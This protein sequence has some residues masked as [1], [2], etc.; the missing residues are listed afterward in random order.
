MNKFHPEAAPVGPQF[1]FPNCSVRIPEQA[2]HKAKNVL[3]EVGKDQLDFYR[4]STH[5]T[6]EGLLNDPVWKAL[7]IPDVFT[8][9]IVMRAQETNMGVPIIFR[10]YGVPAMSL[11]SMQPASSN[12]GLSAVQYDEGY[13]K[14][15]LVG[16]EQLLRRTMK[17]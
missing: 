16:T 5:L 17:L 10:H 3:L 9:L 6:L 13:G 7:E 14:V 4:Q 8:Q 2:Y 15:A 12:N 11:M 1:R